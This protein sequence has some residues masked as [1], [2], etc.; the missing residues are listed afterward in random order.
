MERHR[1]KKH[2]APATQHTNELLRNNKPAAIPPNIQ[3]TEY[4]ENENRRH[5]W[6]LQAHGTETPTN[7]EKG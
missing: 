5:M 3:N 1:R 7:Q 2:R 4:M 6:N